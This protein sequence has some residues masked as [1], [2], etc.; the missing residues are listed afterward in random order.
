MPKAALALLAIAL[1]L[2]GCGADD[3]PEGWTQDCLDYAK[4]EFV[5][6][7]AKEGG[8]VQT[9][10]MNLTR[11]NDWSFHVSA[12]TEEGIAVGVLSYG[13]ICDGALTKFTSYIE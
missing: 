4:E 11:R 13:S 7:A 2:V 6:K 1:M 9:Q 5:A 12:R 8:K 10:S 3:Q